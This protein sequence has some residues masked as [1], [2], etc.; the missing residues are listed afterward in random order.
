MKGGIRVQCKQRLVLA[1]ENLAAEVR[2]EIAVAQSIHDR[3]FDFGQMQLDAGGV[4]SCRN[5]L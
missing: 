2:E 4:Q 1:D 3:P 5:G